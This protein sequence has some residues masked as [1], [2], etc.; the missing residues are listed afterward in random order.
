MSRTSP[1]EMEQL[2]GMTLLQCAGNAE[3][4]AK[5]WEAVG[6]ARA[7]YARDDKEHFQPWE[8]ELEAHKKLGDGPGPEQGG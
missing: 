6:M 5:W 1:T 8:Q 4:W 7:A 3:A 2:A